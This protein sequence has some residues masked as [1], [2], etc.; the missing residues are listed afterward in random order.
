MEFRNK[1]Q[2]MA[3]KY[4]ERVIVRLTKTQK[5]EL[6]RLAKEEGKTISQMMRILIE[7]L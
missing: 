6:D 4:P 5:E 3:E 1:G 2:I 7:G